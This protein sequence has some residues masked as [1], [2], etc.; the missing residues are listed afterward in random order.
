MSPIVGI[1]QDKLSL[2]S[3]SPQLVNVMRH[4]VKQSAD[5]TQKK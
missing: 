4:M 1:E 2:S 5:K 3:S